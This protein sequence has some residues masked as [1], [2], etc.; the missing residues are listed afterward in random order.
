MSIKGSKV[1]LATYLKWGCS[2]V[3][4]DKEVVEDSICFV[5]FTRDSMT[6]LHIY[7][8]SYDENS[9]FC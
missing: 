1:K 6:Q 5:K 3:I 2:G 8:I 4:G 7:Y 9:H